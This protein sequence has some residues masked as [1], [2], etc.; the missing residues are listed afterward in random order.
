MNRTTPATFRGYAGKDAFDRLA[1]GTACLALF[2]LAAGIAV[3]SWVEDGGPPLTLAGRLGRDRRPFTELRFRST[4]NAQPTRV[5]EVLRRTGLEQLPQLINV[6][7]G[8]MS[9]VGPQPRARAELH[10]VAAADAEQDWRF[11]AK[12][13][14]TGLAQLLAPR[15]ARNAG[16]L[17]RLYLSRQSL[18]LDLQLLALSFAAHAVG[19]QRIRRWLRRLGAPGRAHP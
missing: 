15:G 6:L 13:G 3:A 17:D 2:S 1:A 18:A 19:A 14:I 9:L 7:R 11:A 16:R 8:E 5:G 4:R 10:G 12:P